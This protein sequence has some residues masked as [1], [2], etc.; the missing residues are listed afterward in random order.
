MIK[1][2]L[3]DFIPVLLATWYLFSILLISLSSCVNFFILTFL[4]FFLI[5]SL[6]KWRKVKVTPHQIFLKR[7]NFE[8]KI[9]KQ[10]ILV[11]GKAV[12]ESGNPAYLR[13]LEIL[14][15]DFSSPKT[16]K[17]QFLGHIDS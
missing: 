15:I 5:F 1:M 7:A 4:I 10:K 17:A 14:S 8:K 3:C 13:S 2:K 12:G 16:F 11:L 9:A 6:E